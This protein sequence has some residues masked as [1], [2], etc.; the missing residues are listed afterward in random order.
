[1]N[2]FILAATLVT[3][4]AGFAGTAHADMGIPNIPAQPLTT[5]TAAGVVGEAM[6]VFNGT[7][8]PVVADQF[9]QTIVGENEPTLV[10]P[11]D[12]GTGGVAYAQIGR[13]NKAI[14]TALGGSAQLQ[15][16]NG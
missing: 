14:T 12:N 1:M 11:T 9:A 13:A 2:K 16:P 6:P 5:Q 4:L 7:P 10:A 15:Q 8:R 3:A